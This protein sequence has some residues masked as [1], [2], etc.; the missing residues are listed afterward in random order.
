M[1]PNVKQGTPDLIYVREISSIK[2]ENCRLYY[3]RSKFQ[4]TDKRIIRVKSHRNG[5]LYLMEKTI[6][7][8]R[9]RS[10]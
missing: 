7:F 5:Y 10:I 1:I 3:I 4:F 2:K 9:D 6:A 8:L